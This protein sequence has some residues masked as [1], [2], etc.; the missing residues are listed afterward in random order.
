MADDESTDDTGTDEDTE[1][2]EYEAPDKDTWAKITASLEK[3]NGE[4]KKWRMRATGKDEK[5]KPPAPPKDDDNGTPAPTGAKPVD[6]AKVQREAEEAA[7][8]KAKPGLV[9]AAARDALRDAGILL[10]AGKDKADAA[11]AR[12]VRLLDLGEI[13]VDPE[14]GSVSGVDE[15]VKAVKRDYPELFVK[16]GARQIDAGAGSGGN[17]TVDKKDTSANK[18]A[19]M[20]R[21]TA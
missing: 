5:W 21:G 14:D 15:Q 12:A 18:L 4:A 7:L 2:E 16:K 3:A 19:A 11:F 13:D 20:I 8:A 17:G 6:V 9:R 10:P 1:D